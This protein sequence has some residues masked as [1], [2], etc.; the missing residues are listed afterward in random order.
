[1]KL[2][3]FLDGLTTGE[4]S[5]VYIGGKESYGIIAEDYPAI[6]RFINSGLTAL[7]TRFPLKLKEVSIQNYPHIHTYYLRKEFAV[8]NTESNQPIKYIVDSKYAPFIG[9]VLKI[10]QVFSEEGFE[11][12]LNDES[13]PYSVFT[14]E[15]D[16]LVIP[17]N[18][19]T[20]MTSV[21]YRA[22]HEKIPTEESIDPDKISITLPPYLEAALHSYVVSRVFK[23]IGGESNLNEAMLHENQYELV[24]SRVETSSLLNAD[25]FT[26]MKLE[27]NGWV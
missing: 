22:N 5:Q 11:R 6:T 21:I 4:L 9:D 10:D 26:N 13:A 2:S 24:C 1:M 8:S 27:N 12:R 20:N 23:S 15:F 3:D 18:E 17:F 25:Q 19:D 14:P 16:A 7:Y